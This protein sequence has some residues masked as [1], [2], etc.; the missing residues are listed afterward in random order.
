MDCEVLK[1]AN[2]TG[3]PKI[4]LTVLELS[5]TS[6]RNLKMLLFAKSEIT[7]REITCTA[8]PVIGLSHWPCETGY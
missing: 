7:A 6:L 5:Q 2:D 3:F 1:L 4:Q 8:S